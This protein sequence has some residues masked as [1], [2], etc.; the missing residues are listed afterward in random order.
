MSSRSSY[1]WFACARNKGKSIYKLFYFLSL[2]LNCFFLQHLI[3]NTI[4]SAI[5]YLPPC[6]PKSGNDQFDI[7][8]YNAHIGQLSG[9]EIEVLSEVKVMEDVG[10]VI[11]LLLQ[12]NQISKKQSSS[13]SCLY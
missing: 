9:L 2:F 6:S 12:N 11:A 8:R 4:K 3:F 1:S 7:T 10:G 13:C 5:N